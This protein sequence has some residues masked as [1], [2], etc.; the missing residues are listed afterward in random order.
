MGIDEIPSTQDGAERESQMD[1]FRKDFGDAKEMIKEE[2]GLKQIDNLF[3][4]ITKPQ[5]SSRLIE[6]YR[7]LQAERTKELTSKGKGHIHF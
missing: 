1:A 2:S 7:K 4:S 6:Y 5:Y 3:R